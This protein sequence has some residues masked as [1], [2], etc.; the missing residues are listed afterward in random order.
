MGSRQFSTVATSDNLTT[1]QRI[2]GSKWRFRTIFKYC[3]RRQLI[4]AQ[5][6]RMPLLWSI[7]Y[8]SSPSVKTT[9]SKQGVYRE[10]NIRATHKLEQIKR[11]L[12]H[13]LNYRFS[14]FPVSATTKTHAGLNLYELFLEI[15]VKNM[16]DL[17]QKE[18][19]EMYTVLRLVFKG[20]IHPILPNRPR[21]HSYCAAK[22][23][24]NSAPQTAA[25]TFALASVF[26]LFSKGEAAPAP[27]PTLVSW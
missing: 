18:Y 21:Q 15:R 27:E 20:W 6:S 7:Q 2:T 26:I 16:L 8:R 24:I 25:T 4:G 11:F 13:Y 5:L 1:Q 3:D 19:F 23:W 14:C 10:K 12:S 22:N 17:V 9:A